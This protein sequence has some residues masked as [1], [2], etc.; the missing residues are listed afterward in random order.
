M[1]SLMRS[2]ERNFVDDKEAH[3]NYL[4]FL[5]KKQDC[6]ELIWLLLVTFLLVTFFLVRYGRRLFSLFLLFLYDTLTYQSN[7]TAN[8]DESTKKKRSKKSSISKMGVCV[9]FK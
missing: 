2:K 3:K 8:H 6:L 5:L 4:S 9:P 1:T 7:M